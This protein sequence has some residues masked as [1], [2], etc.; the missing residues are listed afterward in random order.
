MIRFPTSTWRVE[1][2]RITSFLSQALS[3]LLNFYM[4]CVLCSLL[5][6]PVARPAHPL[7]TKHFALLPMVT[8]KEFI[9]L[10]LAIWTIALTSLT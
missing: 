2:R 7:Q 4:H 8:P 1:P 6:Y 5:A 9:R 3:W 10:A